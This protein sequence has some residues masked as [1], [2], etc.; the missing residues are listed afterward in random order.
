ML[1]LCENTESEPRYFGPYLLQPGD[2]RLVSDDFFAPP[3]EPGDS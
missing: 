2:L 1:T 3:E